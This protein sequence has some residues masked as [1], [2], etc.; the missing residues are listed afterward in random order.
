MTDNHTSASSTAWRSYRIGKA[1]LWGGLILFLPAVPLL[2]MAL[3]ALRV[4]GNPAAI[5]AFAL[6]ALWLI[7]GL[8]LAKFLCPVCCKRFFV[9]GPLRI[10]NL[11]AR[12]CCH[13][14]ASAPINT[15]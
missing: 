13:C 7:N 12:R 10:G 4:P 9:Y 1:L 6:I 3:H 2:G 14:G 11:W 15:R 5:A 8:W